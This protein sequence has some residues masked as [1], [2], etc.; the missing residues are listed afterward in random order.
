MPG[1]ADDA[2]VMEL[3]DLA[4]AAQGPLAGLMGRGNARRHAG[5][6]VTSTSD[7]NCSVFSESSR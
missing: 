1:I 7:R 5:T 3:F 2:A 6:P 4:G